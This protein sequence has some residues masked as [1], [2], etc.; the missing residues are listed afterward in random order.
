MP[1]VR[2]ISEDE[3]H[4]VGIRKAVEHE[5]DEFLSNFGPGE[6]GCVELN[7]DDPTKQTVRNR[8]AAAAD[9]KGLVIRFLKTKGDNIR[10]VVEGRVEDLIYWPTRQ[11][12]EA[13]PSESSSRQGRQSQNGGSKTVPGRHDDGTGDEATGGKSSGAR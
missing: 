6:Y 8:L 7:R 3:F 1:T 10:F 2:K 13:A 11:I 4:K 5:Y 9:R 12:E